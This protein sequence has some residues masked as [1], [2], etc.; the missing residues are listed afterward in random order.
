MINLQKTCIQFIVCAVFMIIPMLLLHAQESQVL[1]VTPPLFQLSVLPGDVWQS[2]V[3]VVNGNAYPMNVYAEVVNFQATGERGQG[4]FIPILDSGEDKA[5]LAEWIEIPAG[6]HIIQPEQTK[7]IPFFVDVPKDASPGGHYAAI[8]IT[9]QPPAQG[10]EKIAVKTSQAVTSLFFVRIE[11]D[12][13]ED[14]TIREFRTKRNFLEEP[15]AEFVL[16][17]E[18]KGNVHLQPRGDIV[19]TNMWGTVRGT[20]PINNQ[21]HFG[22]VLPESIREFKFTWQSE[23]SLAD[24]GRYKA[25][26]TLAYGEDGIKSTTATTYFWIIPLKGTAITLAILAVFITLIVW[27]VKAY[28]R[29][30]LVLAGVDPD[31]DK[32]FSEIKNSTQLEKRDIKITYK[33]VTAPLKD[34]VLDLRTQLHAVEESIDVV[35]TITQF[36]I[37]YKTFFISMCVLILIF[38]TTVL[39]I[40]NATDENKN[41]QIKFDEAVVQPENIEAN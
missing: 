15:S 16:R 12:V 23:F 18:N 20:V 27:M 10:E 11:G 17:F 7:D 14:G 37:R 8:L 5:T 41:Y 4:K 24:I 33:K 32:D 21:T 1:S 35:K 3:K 38:I 39:Y 26:A 34:G 36:I 6:P 22:N 31:Q 30:M 25:V 40:S 28:V 29:R 13:H 19:L 9:T 2:S